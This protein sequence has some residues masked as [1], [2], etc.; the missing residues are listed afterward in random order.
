MKTEIKKVAVINDIS[1]MGRSSLT[2]ALPIIS[3]LGVQC[4]PFPTAILSCQTNYP[5]FSFFDFTD[6]MIRYKNVWGKMNINFDCIYTG[7]LGSD[8][9]IDIVINFIESNKKSLVLVDPVM[10]DNGVIY[11]T[12]TKALCTRVKELISYA[13]I[14]TPNVTESFILTGQVYNENNINLK[15]LEKIARDITKMGPSKVIITGIVIDNKVHN[16]AYDKE[17]DEVFIVS[18]NYIKKHYCGTGDIFVSIISAMLVRGF[19]FKK[20]I[21]VASNFIYKTIEYTSQYDTDSNEGVMFELFI[22]E[23]II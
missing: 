3:A 9:Q 2:V 13:D 6:E 12:Y 14:V 22:K 8:K 23:L 5:D 1:G 4:C 19:Y 10:G 17:K 11:D 15:F 16:L 21:E 18:T 7:F 20:C